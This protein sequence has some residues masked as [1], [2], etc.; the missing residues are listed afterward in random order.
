MFVSGDS[1]ASP[2]LEA[3][4]EGDTYNPVHPE[5]L[6][7]R[8]EAAGFTEAEVRTNPFRMGGHGPKAL[9]RSDQRR[10]LFLGGTWNGPSIRALKAASSG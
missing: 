3:H 8:L 9:T 4:H 2:E 10:S 7:Q 1:L 6:A 5:V